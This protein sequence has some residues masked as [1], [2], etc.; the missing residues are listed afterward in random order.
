VRPDLRA[1]FK[2]TNRQLTFLLLSE[3]RKP[4]TR[5]QSRWASTYDDHIE[6]HC[7]SFHNIPQ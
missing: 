6:I 4:D 2:Y 7:L 1:F 5:A 3:L